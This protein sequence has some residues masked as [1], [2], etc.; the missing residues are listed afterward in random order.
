MNERG[1]GGGGRRP[2]AT[3]AKPK[4][5]P[6]VPPE[7]HWKQAP[8]TTV[9][10]AVPRA[11]WR[12]PDETFP[13]TEVVP[14]R[15]AQWVKS[16]QVTAPPAYRPQWEAA[17]RQVTREQAEKISSLERGIADAR[18]GLDQ[19]R[20]A[21]DY[22]ASDPEL[23]RLGADIDNWA[24]QYG[25]KR[26][27]LTEKLGRLADTQESRLRADARRYYAL[28]QGLRQLQIDLAT[29]KRDHGLG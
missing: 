2:L 8:A 10:P 14:A 26:E 21:F 11:A 25:P 1:N 29:Y 28:E 19:I 18:K 5:P 23:Q 7:S 22:K 6:P 12:R 27:G 16:P 24:N 4:S 3:E 20:E 13:K 15:K 17:Q 9:A